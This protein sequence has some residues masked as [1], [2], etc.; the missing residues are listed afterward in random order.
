MDYI[1]LESITRR[2]RLVLAAMRFLRLVRP[3]AVILWPWLSN[4][5]FIASK[6]LLIAILLP[7]PFLPEDTL[8]DHLTDC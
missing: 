2:R 1:A 3:R 6:L 7:A 8:H 5:R 4:S